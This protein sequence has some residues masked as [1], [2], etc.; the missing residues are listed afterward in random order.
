MSC[1]LCGDV[2]RCDPHHRSDKARP[3]FRPHFEPGDSG[4]NPG[5]TDA[6]LIDPEGFDASE[7]QFA[8][9]LEETPA[10]FSRP[11]FVVDGPEA[12]SR[13]PARTH[14]MEDERRNPEPFVAENAG[15]GPTDLRVKTSTHGESAAM[16]CAES[17][18]GG[19]TVEVGTKP[20]LPTATERVATFANETGRASPPGA[21]FLPE[22][23]EP[24]LPPNS[25]RQEVAARV[26]RYHS[27]R[28]P[29]A[30][31]YPSLRLK[32][33]ADSARADPIRTA[34]ISVRFSPNPPSIRAQVQAAVQREQPV[35]SSLAVTAIEPATQIETRLPPESTGKLIAFPRSSG[36]APVRLEE[37]A[38]PVID[39]P[40]ILE[41]PE[42]SPPPP[43]LGGILIEPAVEQEEEKRPGIDVPLQSAALSRRLLATAADGMLVAAAVA[44]FGYVFFRMSSAALPL[45][46][47]IPAGSTLAALV[48]AA[49]QYL[50][51]V[52]TGTTP[53]LKL[54]RLQLAR[55]DGSPA[56]RRRRRWRVLV[57][58]LS[59]ASLGMGCAWYFL[60]EDALCWHDRIT[61]TYLAPISH[62]K[63][64]KP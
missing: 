36:V 37:L 6:V 64:N 20:V 38:E 26:H 59:A 54:A 62:P 25:W 40:R 50:F 24:P 9:S 39:A 29:R 12:F 10:S 46:R 34:D 57:S 56:S 49:Y 16:R 32:F 14:D 22:V 58:L 43:A 52:H 27:R 51:L 4:T 8:A 47:I 1:P 11:R 13:T 45:S 60:D 30:P 7:Q 42:V 17:V 2:C 5:A 15:N 63:H 19:H 21:E 41:V 35:V 48:W 33:E 28:K 55:F 61:Q 18:A 31:R 23:P 3:Q 44:V 53:G